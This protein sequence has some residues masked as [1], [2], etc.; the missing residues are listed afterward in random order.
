MADDVS[1]PTII[2][3][4][5]AFLTAQIR[6]LSRPLQPSSS[7]LETN[8]ESENALRQ[9]NI[10]DAL[11]KL[12]DRL[13]RHNKLKYGPQ[14][15]RHVAEQIDALYWSAGE[16]GVVTLGLGEEWVERGTDYSMLCQSTRLLYLP[17]SF[18]IRIWI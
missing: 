2:A 17:A 6:S 9:R 12:N 14:A 10:D 7:F 8:A 16:R 15:Q 1:P 3:L 11:Q 5:S 18:V 4:K 13:K